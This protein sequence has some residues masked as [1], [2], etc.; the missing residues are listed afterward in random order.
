MLTTT[1]SHETPVAYG[2][3]HL[4]RHHIQPQKEQASPPQS[5]GALPLLLCGSDGSRGHLTAARLT[6]MGK[7]LHRQLFLEIR[8]V[9]NYSCTTSMHMQFRGVEWYPGL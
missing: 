3:L 9:W 7:G 6:Y 5:S 2:R 4:L 8:V 1:G